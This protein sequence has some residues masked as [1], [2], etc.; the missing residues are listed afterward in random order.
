MD[1]LRIQNIK[2]K[3]LERDFSIDAIT[4]GVAYVF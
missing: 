1:Y 4:A 3:A 2:E